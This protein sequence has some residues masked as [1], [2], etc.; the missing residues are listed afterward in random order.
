MDKKIS[1]H[2]L[3]VWLFRVMR[4]DS[5]KDAQAVCYY[6]E[7]FSPMNL[8]ALLFSRYSKAASEIKHTYFE[9]KNVEEIS[10]KF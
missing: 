5:A 7:L 8:L 9:E 10:C 6:V 4:L 3:G 2:I 1:N